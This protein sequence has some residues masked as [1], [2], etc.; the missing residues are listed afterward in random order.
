M[1][2]FVKMEKIEYAAEFKRGRTSLDDDERLKRLKTAIT[3]DDIEKVHQMVLN[4][5]R[6]KVREIAEAL[7]ISEEHVCYILTEELG[8]R[9]L[10]A[11]WVPRLLTLDQ[12]R[13]RMNI[14]NALLAQLRHNK[15]EFWRRLIIADETWIH[16]YT[17]ETKTQLNQWTAKGELALKK[18]KAVPL[19]EKVMAIVFWDSRG[20][21]LIDYL[22]KGKTKITGTYY[23]SL[24]DKLKAE[25]V[26]KRPHLQKKKI[27]F[28]QAKSSISAIAL[29]KIY[30]LRFK[31]LNHPPYSPDLAPSNFF[32]F[33]K[34]KVA[35]GGQRFSSKEEAITFV[36]NYFAEKDAKYYLDGLKRWEHHWEKCIDLQGDYIEK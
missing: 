25:I 33:P 10:T 28:H 20:V 15:R 24:L 19:A 2:V 30:E 35:L 22:E 7:K 5:N 34:L 6:I 18:A 12:K 14:S 26:K 23:A 36:N 3:D 9:K 11:R 31:L 17:A 32:L 27:L 13:V 1:S 4:D 21:V 8:M 16:Y 29:S